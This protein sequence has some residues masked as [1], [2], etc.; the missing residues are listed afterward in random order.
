LKIKRIY[1]HVDKWEE[2]PGGMWRIVPKEQ[3][4]ELLIKAIE[5]AN[6]TE[7]FGQYMRKVIEK[8]KHSCEHNLS[9]KG[10]NRIAW[11]GQAACCLGIKCPE[12]IM[13]QAWHYLSEESREKANIKAWETI[14]LW[15]KRH[16][17]GLKYE[18]KTIRNECI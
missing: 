1:H 6:D 15:E 10:I 9:Y 17:E 14:Q 4:Q 12:Y 8:W 3:E 11:L 5:F 7:R 13:R 16:L 2:V 18:Q